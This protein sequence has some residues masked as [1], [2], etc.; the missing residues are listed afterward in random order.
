M[1]KSEVQKEL[2]RFRD[3]VVSQS[4]RNLSRLRKNSS[5][6][7]Y[8]SIKGKV[9]VMTNSISIEFFMEDYGIFVDEGVKGKDPSKVSPNAKIKGQQAPNS[10]Y[11]FGSG[12]ARGSWGKF[13]QSIEKWARSKNIRLR[14]EKG[15]YKK[16]NYK[17]IAHIIASNIY[18]RGLKPSMFFTRPFEAAY[19]KLP[20]E[21]VE[22]YGLD[23]IKLFNQQVDQIL[24]QN[25]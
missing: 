20:Q 21:L 9:N 8:D 13:K 2:E 14:D 7:L 15:K 17:S 11:K 6:S 1:E 22:K 23:A 3:Y 19:K 4:R 25:G 12:S 24:R 10:R 18:A 5:R 16:G